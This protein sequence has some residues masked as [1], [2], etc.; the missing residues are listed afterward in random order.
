MVVLEF[1]QI[2]EG[3]KERKEEEKKDGEKEIKVFNPEET[4][5]KEREKEQKEG[6]EEGKE[7]KITT[8]QMVGVVW[9]AAKRIGEIEISNHVAIAK[10][11]K[12]IALLLLDAHEEVLPLAESGSSLSFFSSFPYFLVLL[13]SLLL[14]LLFLIRLFRFFFFSSFS[15]LFYY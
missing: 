7:G 14:F 12:E 5:K 6:E 10:E 4:E 2:E 3:G 13:L 9:E 15:F 1:K 8:T 11:M